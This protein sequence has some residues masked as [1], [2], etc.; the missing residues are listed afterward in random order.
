LRGQIKGAH[1]LDFR[2]TWATACNDAGGGMLRHEFRRT[3]VRN[4][5][6]AGVPERVAM[7]V[8]GQ[9][10]RAVLDRYHIVSPA[11]LQDVARPVAGTATGTN[12]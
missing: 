6:N 5:V 2:K 12:R 10:T 4:T 3:A 8:T 11:D 7:T 1:Q 9:K